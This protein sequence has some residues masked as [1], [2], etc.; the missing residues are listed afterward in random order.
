MFSSTLVYEGDPF[1]RYAYFSSAFRAINILTYF[2]IFSTFIVFYEWVSS[3]HMIALIFFVILDN[4][5]VLQ[6]CP[7]GEKVRATK[8]S[9]FF[10]LAWIVF[11]L[12][13]T[14]VKGSLLFR[15][16]YLRDLT[17]SFST[18]SFFVYKGD[19]SVGENVVLLL[20]PDLL[21]SLMMLLYLLCVQEKPWVN[22]CNLRSI[23]QVISKFTF[24]GHNFTIELMVLVSVV[25]SSNVCTC[26]YVFIIGFRNLFFGKKSAEKVRVTSVFLIFIISALSIILASLSSN[27]DFLVENQKILLGI[28]LKKV[29]GTRFTPLDFRS[30]YTW[31][32]ISQFFI[33]ILS[34]NLLS[35]YSTRALFF[36]IAE[37]EN[38]RD[39]SEDHP[40]DLSNT[41]A[42]LLTDSPSDQRAPEAYKQSQIPMNSHYYQYM[43]RKIALILRLNNPK[44]IVKAQFLRELEPLKFDV[45]YE[46]FKNTRKGE[47]RLK[48]LG[49]R[50]YLSEFFE[51][52]FRMVIGIVISIILML[53]INFLQNVFTLLFLFH[54]LYILIGTDRNSGKSFAVLEKI[55]H[56]SL[57]CALAFFCLGNFD[58]PVIRSSQNFAVYFFGLVPES[59]SFIRAF[60]FVLLILLCKVTEVQLTRDDSIDPTVKAIRSEAKRKPNNWTQIYHYILESSDYWLVFTLIL[61]SLTAAVFD[62][63]DFLMVCIFIAQMLKIALSYK[64]SKT[65][66]ILI[67]GYLFLRFILFICQKYISVPPQYIS[68]FDIED[69]N[70]FIFS[71]KNTPLIFILIFEKL[72]QHKK[73]RFDQFQGIIRIQ[74]FFKWIQNFRTSTQQPPSKVSEG[75][76]I[77]IRLTMVYILSFCLLLS[78]SLIKFNL[79]VLIE[80]MVSIFAVLLISKE[81]FFLFPKPKESRAKFLKVILIALVWLLFF[82]MAVQLFCFVFMFAYQIRLVRSPSVRALPYRIQ[83]RK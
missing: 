73:P 81:F 13:M 71:N 42:C 57:G 12:V 18:F 50:Y 37:Q 4:M 75:W 45:F 64:L 49:L 58:S 66:F 9:I 23:N 3:F 59:T 16:L 70:K 34:A 80:C 29:W 28:F 53:I 33:F 72:S 63:I 1:A 26:C 74:S 77:I 54:F 79:W 31:L 32:F 82:S 68:F 30:Q 19:F 38:L 6:K 36:S 40:I 65:N 22:I 25:L 27:T 48:F 47:E 61:S 69:R 35:K 5:N 17:S 62:S 78:I 55:F 15:K 52:N 76:M 43:I 60:L 44:K 67:T 7:E 21:I 46:S 51:E 11:S 39:P 14:S 24:R 56:V 2:L 20:L 8:S 83:Y 41:E 10:S